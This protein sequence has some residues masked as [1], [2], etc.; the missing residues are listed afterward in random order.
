MNENAMATYKVM[1]EK[2]GYRFQFFCD[3]SGAL[4]CTTALIPENTLEEALEIAW[5]TEGKSHLN[6]CHKCGRYVS[7]VMYNADVLEC[8]KCTPWENPPGF[9]QQCGRR[10]LDSDIHCPKCGAVVRYSQKEE[11]I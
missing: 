5:E 11:S 1:E 4:A 3:L 7:D 6:C 8:V 9:C 10:L 2:G